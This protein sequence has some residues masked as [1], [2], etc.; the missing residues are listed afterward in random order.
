MQ[1]RCMTVHDIDR[2]NEVISQQMKCVMCNTTEDRRRRHE[3]KYIIESRDL[4]EKFQ[5]FP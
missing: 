4:T 1:I 3:F 2:Q 5:Q